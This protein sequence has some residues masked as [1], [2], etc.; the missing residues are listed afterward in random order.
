MYASFSPEVRGPQLMRDLGISNAFVSALCRI[1][2]TKLSFAFRQLKPLPEYE[3][4]RLVETLARLKEIRKALGIIPLGLAD[5]R[6]VQSLLDEMDLQRIT[7]QQL[8]EA[9]QNLFGGE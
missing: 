1:E 7:P 9:V 3:G 2:P 8:G 4:R 5:V 6:A